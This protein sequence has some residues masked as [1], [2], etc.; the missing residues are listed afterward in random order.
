MFLQKLSSGILILLA[1]NLELKIILQNI[2]RR[3]VDNDL[4]NISP[5]NYFLVMFLPTKFHQYC[6]APFGRCGHWGVKLHTPFNSLFSL[7]FQFLLS[8]RCDYQYPGAGLR[9]WPVSSGLL[10]SGG[11]RRA[12]EMSSGDILQ[13]HPPGLRRPVPQLYC[14]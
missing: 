8:L 5:S 1:I 13:Y 4:I 6:Q 14:R 7:L 11:D 10:L 12:A 9:C 2:W 3:V